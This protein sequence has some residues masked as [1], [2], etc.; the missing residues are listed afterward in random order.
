MAGDPGKVNPPSRRKVTCEEFRSDVEKSSKAVGMDMKVKADD[1]AKTPAELRVLPP[2]AVM[3]G[4]EDILG[5][6][7]VASPMF[8]HDLESY[9]RPIFEKL[10]CK[11]FTCQIGDKTTC[12]CQG[13]GKTGMV[14]TEATNQAFAIQFRSRK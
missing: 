14:R 8:G 5:S 13:D 10:G 7:F 1:W 4:S 3:C 2:G 6:V 12:K 11:P 9:Y